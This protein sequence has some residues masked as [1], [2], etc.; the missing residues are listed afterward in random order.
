MDGHT[1]LQPFLFIPCRMDFPIPL[2]VNSYPVFLKLQT[3]IFSLKCWCW[4]SLI[5]FREK[6]GIQGYF[7][8]FFEHIEVK[9]GMIYLFDIIGTCG[10]IARHGFCKFTY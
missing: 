9:K 5:L 6:N 4:T 8:G 1:I 10:Y 7:N 3:T 2:F